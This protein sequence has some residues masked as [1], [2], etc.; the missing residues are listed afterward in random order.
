MNYA[1]NESNPQSLSKASHLRK[2]YV[3]FTVI[4]NLNNPFK[5]VHAN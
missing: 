2:E 5:H 1:N 4:L 3:K